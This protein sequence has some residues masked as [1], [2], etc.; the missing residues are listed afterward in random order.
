[1]SLALYGCGNSQGNNNFSKGISAGS[2]QNRKNRRKGPQSR[3]NQEIA[4]TSKHSGN[5]RGEAKWKVRFQLS[6]SRK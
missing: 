4:F 3:E 5:S 1:M 2:L 6:R